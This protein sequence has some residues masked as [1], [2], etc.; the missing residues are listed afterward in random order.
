[1]KQGIARVEVALRHYNQ[2]HDMTLSIAIGYD[3]FHISDTITQLLS[4]ADSMMYDDK[5]RKKEN[6]IKL[7]N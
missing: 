6:E 3:R 5:H 2:T 4:R 7:A 1:M